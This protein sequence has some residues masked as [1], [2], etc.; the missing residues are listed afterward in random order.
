MQPVM[1]M[2]LDVVKGL[3]NYYFTFVDVM[4]FKVPYPTSCSNFFISSF[5]AL[6]VSV[7][8]NLFY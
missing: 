5:S 1:Q 4:M 2:H 8:Y 6:K 3:S 7:N